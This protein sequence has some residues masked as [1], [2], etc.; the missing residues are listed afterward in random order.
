MFALYVHSMVWVKISV[1]LT[2]PCTKLCSRCSITEA[3]NCFYF[4]LGFLTMFT[5][6]VYSMVRIKSVLDWLSTAQICVH[7]A[8]SLK[9]KTILRYYR[10]KCF[11]L[12]SFRFSNKGKDKMQSN[13]KQK[14]EGKSPHFWIVFILAFLGSICG[15]LLGIMIQNLGWNVFSIC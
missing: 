7:A 10:V 15:S 3:K 4:S 2:I 11:A 14:S 1:G 12:L 13:E 6:Y 8:Q 9:G 5:L